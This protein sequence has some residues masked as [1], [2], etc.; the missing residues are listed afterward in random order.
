MDSIIKVVLSR[1]GTISK[2]YSIYLPSL[3]EPTDNVYCRSTDFQIELMQQR[4]GLFWGGN[5]CSPAAH[6]MVLYNKEYFTRLWNR[7]RLGLTPIA[8]VQTRSGKHCLNVLVMSIFVHILGICVSVNFCHH[9]CQC[10]ATSCDCLFSVISQGPSL[11]VYF[12]NF[13][14]LFRCI[15]LM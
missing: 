4:G 12:A 3:H 1:K 2:F 8:P 13:V 9:I 6:V 11:P 15:I 14:A 5:T 10:P 7:S